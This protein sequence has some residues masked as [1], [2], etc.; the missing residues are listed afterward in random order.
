MLH[1]CYMLH[2]SSYLCRPTLLTVFDPSLSLSLWLK[3]STAYTVI[4]SFSV[5]MFLNFYNIACVF[6]FNSLLFMFMSGAKTY[7]TP[8]SWWGTFI[9]AKHKQTWIHEGVTLE[10]PDSVKMLPFLPLTSPTC[11]L[12]SLQEA[13][14]AF[15]KDTETN[16]TQR[17][18]VVSLIILDWGANP[19][20]CTR[21]HL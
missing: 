7:C 4:D 1:A 14:H 8:D 9:S 3:Y 19:E 12:G 16:G 17:L 15:L 11:K 5:L 13:R 20:V 21:P 2:G 10:Q 6:L 18:T